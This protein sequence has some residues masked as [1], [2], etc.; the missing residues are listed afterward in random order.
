MHPQL[1]CSFPL[2]PPA[3]GPR[4]PHCSGPSPP[5]PSWLLPL[6]QWFPCSF[7]PRSPAF[8]KLFC[9]PMWS[10]LP[11]RPW[12]SLVTFATLAHSFLRPW[13]MAPQALPVPPPSAP[14]CHQLRPLAAL[15]DHRALSH[16]LTRCSVG[17]LVPFPTGHSLSVLS[18]PVG[19]LWAVQPDLPVGKFQGGARRARS[20]LNSLHR[21]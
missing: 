8:P 4:H 13:L 2:A 9:D 10:T 7:L 6:A 15:R 14:P 1:L 3:T 11:A 12:A 19:P 16:S 21:T 17:W 18:Q 5:A 20:L